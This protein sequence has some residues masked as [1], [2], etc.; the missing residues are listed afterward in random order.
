MK[1]GPKK[2]RK[3]TDKAQKS[4]AKEF[5]VRSLKQRKCDTSQVKYK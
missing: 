4:S 5:R 1:R 2:K 3:K